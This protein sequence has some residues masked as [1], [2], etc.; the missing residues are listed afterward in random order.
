MGDNHV[1]DSFTCNCYLR[2]R[3]DV[4]IGVIRAINREL[5]IIETGDS[6]AGFFHGKELEEL[7]QR[8]IKMYKRG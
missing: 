2:A 1:C 7:R 6:V 4:T 5:D 3:E 8:L